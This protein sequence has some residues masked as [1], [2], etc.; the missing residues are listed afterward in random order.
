MAQ[1]IPEIEQY[2]VK[3]KSLLIQIFDVRITSKF[4]YKVFYF[5]SYRS[6]FKNYSHKTKKI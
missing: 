1:N 2:A 3:L 5:N 6:N 4:F